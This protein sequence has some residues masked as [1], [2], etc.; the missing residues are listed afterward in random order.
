M[1]VTC[2]ILMGLATTSAWAEGA[3]APRDAAFFCTFK[4]GATRVEVCTPPDNDTV[5]YR[6]G[7]RM[8][9]P[10]LALTVD[11]AG[12]VTRP[13]PGIGRY[14]YQTVSFLNAGYTYEVWSSVDRLDEAARL[15]GGITVMKEEAIVAHL[16]CDDGSVQDD[17][18]ALF[19]RIEAARARP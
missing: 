9:E 4:D 15:Q 3:C 2:A 1:R 17:L 19:D 5:T 11:L 14:Y 13:W 7:A 18:L 12:L 16:E 8:S 10:E 6:Y